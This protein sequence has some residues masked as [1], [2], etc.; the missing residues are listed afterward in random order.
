[1]MVRLERE[2]LNFLFEVLERERH[3]AQLALGIW[4]AMVR[5]FDYE[6]NGDNGCPTVKVDNRK[7]PP[8]CSYAADI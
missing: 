6:F 5:I 8:P 3:L 2:S 4:S 7:S 1:M